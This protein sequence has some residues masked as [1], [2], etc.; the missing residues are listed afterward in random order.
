MFDVL[1]RI[2]D[3]RLARNWSEYQLSV[4]S[5]LPQ[6]TISSWYRKKMLP[7]IPSLKRIC[8][9]FDLSLAQFFA[10]ENCT[11]LTDD[12]L[13]LIKQWELLTAE[14]KQAILNLIHSIIFQ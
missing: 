2:T 1:Q 11:E 7:T 14:Q 6:S 10:V 5:G 4:R 12:Q 13:S 9:A 3:L 8:D